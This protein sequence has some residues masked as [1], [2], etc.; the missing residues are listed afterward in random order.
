MRENFDRAL[1]FVLVHEGG[2]ADHPKDPGG[3]TMKGVTLETFRRHFG[4]D[5]SVNDLRNITPEQ[6]ACVY[7]TGYWDKCS[8]DQLPGGVDYAVF[9]LAVNS[10]PGRAAKFLQSAIGAVQDGAI[11]PATLD[12]VGAREP[13]SIINSICD[14]R[15]SFLQHLE[16]FSTFGAGWTKRVGSVRQQALDM[17]RGVFSTG[18]AGLDTGSADVVPNLDFDIVR[19]G[20]EGAWV[21]KLQKALAI[22]ADGK[23]GPR[24]EAALKAFQEAHGLE[25]DGIAGRNTY[26]VLGLIG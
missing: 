6:L 2:F 3:A 24:T 21:I 26:R 7:R 18:S 10:G 23:F 14:Q 15:L 5:K 25:A 11:G 20:S 13:P 9:D 17:V 19:L 1:Q 8:C 4:A 22:E 16:T 12:K